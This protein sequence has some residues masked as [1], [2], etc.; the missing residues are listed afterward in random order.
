MIACDVL[1]GVLPAPAASKEERR[2]GQMHTLGVCLDFKFQGLG[3]P[4]ALI[5]VVEAPGIADGTK[6]LFYTM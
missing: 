2:A 6:V 3:Q 1:C 5:R 4:L